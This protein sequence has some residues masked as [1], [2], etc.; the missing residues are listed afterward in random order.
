MHH[1]TCYLMEILIVELPSN[2][3]YMNN[4]YAI[5]PN[6]QKIGYVIVNLRTDVVEGEVNVLSQAISQAD[7]WAELLKEVLN[8][9]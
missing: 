3:V 1:M 9:L 6:K 4:Y 8:K 2:A 7:V 5:Y